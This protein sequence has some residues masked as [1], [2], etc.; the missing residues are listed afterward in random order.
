[1]PADASEPEG[2]G[3]M[4]QPLLVL[5]DS[6]CSGTEPIAAEGACHRGSTGAGRGGLSRGG[7]F[8]DQF[9]AV[10]AGSGG[11]LSARGRQL[12]IVGRWSSV[13][14]RWRARSIELGDFVN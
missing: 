4:R 13:A 14:S 5:R 3:W 2:A 10:G 7:D 8:G 1:Q 9:G 11:K 6:V 12:S